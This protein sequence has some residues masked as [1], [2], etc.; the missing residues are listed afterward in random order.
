MSPLDNELRQTLAERASDID[1]V[2]DLLSQV[3]SRAQAIHRRR[4]GAAGLGGTAA[5]AAVVVLGVALTGGAG[6]DRVR[7]PQT[8]Q[9]S[10]S[11]GPSSPSPTPLPSSGSGH[12]VA[13]AWPRVGPNPT[14]VRWD[15]VVHS[16]PSQVPA[17][18]GAVGGPSVLGS[19][20]TDGGPVAVFV[21]PVGD[22][23]VAGA[24]L[25]SDPGTA[26]AVHDIAPDGDV[27]FVGVV[28][29]VQASGGAV[30]DGVVVGAPTTG[31]I[32]FK[33][34]EQPTF[35]STESTG[36]PRWSTVT[37]GQVTPGQ[38]VAQVELLD[39]NGDTGR[40]IYSGPIQVG[41]TF[42]NP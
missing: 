38:P 41:L 15:A 24:V 35:V 28:V 9:A 10:E 13:M 19:G 12:I 30:D 8:P 37:L 2:N 42:P 14:W 4:V 1:D 22:H 39:G 36:D 34:P 17:G 27:P 29:H 23:L 40:P 21:V 6:T 25:E 11:S 7:V 3:E 18:F 20:E 32:L 16:L 26:V 5:V 31:Q 33:L